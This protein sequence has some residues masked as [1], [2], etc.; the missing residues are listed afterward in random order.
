MAPYPWALPEGSLEIMNKY[1]SERRAFKKSIR[2]FGQI[3]KHIAQSYAEYQALRAYIYDIARTMEAQVEKDK[4][5]R[6][7]C[8]G[9]KLLA[10]SLGKNIADRAIQVLGGYG[11]VGEVYCG[12]ALERRQTAGD[13]R[14][15]RGSFGK[16]YLQRPCPL[17]SRKD[18]RI[19][20]SKTGGQFYPH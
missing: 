16:K 20:A 19:M 11:Y 17:L 12:K 6:L 3:Q 8:D 7:A 2:S 15:H 9:V 18:G 5:H 13:W 4:N 14:R 1:A 10:S